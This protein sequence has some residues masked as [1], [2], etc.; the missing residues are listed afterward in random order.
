MI[1]KNATLIT[2]GITMQCDVLIKDGMIAAIQHPNTLHGDVIVDASGLYLSHGFIDIHVHGGGGH[3][4]MDGTVEAWKGAS[5]LHLRHGTTAMVPTT[6]AAQTQDLLDMF[7]IYKQCKPY[8]PGGAKLLGLHIEGPYLAPAQCGAQDPAF[9]RNPDPSEYKQLLDACPDIL[10]WTIAPELPGALAMGDFLMQNGVVPTIG[11]SEATYE[12]V[13]E[14]MLH[15]FA[16]IAHLYSA[17]S[18]IVRE[19]G[20][21]K[22]GIVESAYLLEGLTCE[23]IADGCHL[24]AGLLQMA[25]RFIGPDR[26][27]LV[28][29]AMRA[30]GQTEGESTLGSLKNGQRVIIEDGV[31]KMPDRSAFAGSVCTAD[32]LVRN[33][34]QLGGATMA[35]AIKMMTE[36]PARV[37][38]L[39][40]QTG[41]V[42]VGRAADLVAFDQDIR[43]R[44]VMTDGQIRWIAPNAEKGGKYVTKI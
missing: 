15:G 22:E 41:I 33:A 38:G 10:L 7:D 8:L 24:P 34:I 19:M 16:H 27:C 13:C 23:L 2:R 36:T 25:Y 18:T 20:F 35:D 30:A 28:T 11:H 37:L 3:D 40:D 43:V 39:S 32:R 29:D 4:F 9:I 44:M 5:A 42:A 21:R 12:Q 31:A 14:S 6:L 26:L 17:T 1:I